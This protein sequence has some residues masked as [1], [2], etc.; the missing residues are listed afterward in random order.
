MRPCS[1]LPP[2]SIA[3]LRGI[4]IVGDGLVHAGAKLE[5][6]GQGH[7][8][9]VFAHPTNP[10]LILKLPYAQQGD[11]TTL[12]EEKWNA[13]KLSEAGLSPRYFR[14]VRVA[15]QHLL[16]KERVHG[17]TFEAL[18]KEGK[19]R[20]A[21]FRLF[22]SLLEGIKN[23]GFYMAGL[24]SDDFMIGTTRS[25]PHRRAFLIDAEEVMVLTSADESQR[26]RWAFDLE[27]HFSLGGYPLHNSL[28]GTRWDDP[29]FGL[30]FL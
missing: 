16:V 26:L 20:A 6:L 3:A 8:G 9:S 4:T 19:F 27:T 1:L 25:S 10:D 13:R 23:S 24:G 7:H 11:R 29:T 30:G 22:C 2:S 28:G 21:E 15:G 14:S 18:L 12:R 17:E 5:L